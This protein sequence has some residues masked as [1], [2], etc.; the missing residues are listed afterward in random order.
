MDHI[1]ERDT[2]VAATEL[3]AWNEVDK[4]AKTPII[5]YVANSHLDYLRGK[6]KALDMWKALVDT[7]ERKSVASRIFLKKKL[8]HMTC[9]EGEP[10]SGY[11]IKFEKAVRDLKAAG[12]NMEEGGVVMQL[13][14]LISLHFDSCHS[15]DRSVDAMNRWH[16]GQW[17]S[18]FL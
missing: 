11:F 10:L 3:N 6:A 13:Q 9:G 17:V 2:A 12:G 4:G 18:R 1:K 5:K 8:V 16:L 14:C 15:F 7:F